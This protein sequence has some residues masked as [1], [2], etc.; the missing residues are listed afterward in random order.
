M[1]GEWTHLDDAARMAA[2]REK[3][4]H[5]GEK[6]LHCGRKF[7]TVGRRFCMR[8]EGFALWKKV[9]HEEGFCPVGGCTGPTL[10]HGWV[11]WVWS[12]MSS[13]EGAGGSAH[14]QGG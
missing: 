13:V 8:R 7:C 12:G 1:H 9:L 3:V 11:V 2:L 5:C 14:L 4:L 10:L 6:V